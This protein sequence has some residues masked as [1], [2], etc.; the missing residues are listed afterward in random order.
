MQ[1]NLLCFC[2]LLYVQHL[3]VLEFQLLHVLAGVLLL[4]GAE[5]ITLRIS[6]LVTLTVV[7]DEQVRRPGCRVSESSDWLSSAI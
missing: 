4:L 7:G 2:K 6:Q 5:V 3:P 1:R